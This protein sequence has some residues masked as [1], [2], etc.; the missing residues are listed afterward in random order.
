MSS[1]LSYLADINND[2]KREMK[3]S[4]ERNHEVL[5]SLM[6]AIIKWEEG[7]QNIISSAPVQT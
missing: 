6:S 5:N 3:T 2:E 4:F 7:G 1:E